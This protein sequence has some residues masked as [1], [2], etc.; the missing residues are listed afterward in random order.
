[1]GAGASSLAPPELDF[2]SLVILSQFNV[3]QSEIDS[4][5]A[6]FMDY[7]DNKNGFWSVQEAF[8]LLDE[9]EDSVISP[10][11]RRLFNLACSTNDG[12]LNFEDFLVSFLCFCALS[13]EELYQFLFMTIDSDRNGCVTK[14]EMIDFFSV[15]TAKNNLIFPPNNLDGLE[16]FYD[17]NWTKLIFDEFVLLCQ[18]FQVMPYCVFHL[19][20][21]LREALLGKTFWAIWDDEREELY[22]QL[23]DEQRVTYK[24]LDGQKVKVIRT[25]RYTMKEILEF[26]KRKNTS[27]SSDLSRSNVT[28]EK[29]MKILHSPLVNIFRNKASPYYVLIETKEERELRKRANTRTKTSIF[30]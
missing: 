15:R 4:L 22:S 24:E 9:T 12:Q 3:N 17:G 30:S 18:R 28:K 8:E 11:L 1:M 26:I 25:T 10:V 19:Q 13:K 6:L 29:D 7:D 5:F 16:R 23:D 2:H 21:L 14:N 20:F 27:S